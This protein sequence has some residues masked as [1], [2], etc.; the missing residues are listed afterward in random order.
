MKIVV[1]GALGHIGSALIRELPHSF[2]NS[3]II[4]IDDLSTQRYCSLF[5][6]P[7]NAQYCFVEGKVQ[8]LELFPLL[9]GADVVIHLAATT[10]AAG[11]ADKPELIYQNNFESTRLLAEACKNQNVPLVFPSS[12][13]IYGSQNALVDENC[14]DL[15]PQSPY[16][17]CK[18]KEEI[19]LKDMFEKGLKG[20]ICRLGTIYGVS[21]GMR[22]HTAVNKFCWQAVM[23]QPITVWETAIDQKRPYLALEDAVK[24]M[25]WIIEHTLY[26]GDIYNIV[27]GNHTVRDVLNVIKDQIPEINIKY[28]QH[29]IM[30]QLS[31]EVSSEKFQKTGFSFDGSLDQGVKNTINFLRNANG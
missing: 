9:K 20:S 25:G 17:E 4:L 8:S 23:Q 2:L 24:A 3:Q 19:F 16:A 31:Y 22:F 27:T 5:E 12:T 26:K 14:T 21:P 30:N 15:L 10:D 7:T 1:T 29:Q 18:I 6:L 11:T 28:V 13:S